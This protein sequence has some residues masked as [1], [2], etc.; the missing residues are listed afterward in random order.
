MSRTDKSRVI[1][2]SGCL[3]LVKIEKLRGRVIAKEYEVS[4][5]DSEN[6]LELDDDENYTT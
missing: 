6:V 1:E 2:N 4:F 5:G 3:G